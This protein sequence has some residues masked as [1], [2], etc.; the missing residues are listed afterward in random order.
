M[1]FALSNLKTWLR[2]WVKLRIAC[3]PARSSHI[4]TLYGERERGNNQFGAMV[5]PR[6]RFTVGSIK[7]PVTEVKT[8]TM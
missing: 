4:L 2:A 5:Q 3:S 6:C 1:Y 7:L 8:P